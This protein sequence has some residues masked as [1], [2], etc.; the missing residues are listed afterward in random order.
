MRR[1]RIEAVA[2]VLLSIVLFVAV[3][4]LWP[5]L[6]TGSLV[7]TF[8]AAPQRWKRQILGMKP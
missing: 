6:P 8:L 2:L 3:G 4:G 7:V 1:F 5:L